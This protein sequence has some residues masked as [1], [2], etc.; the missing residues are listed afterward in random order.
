[1][2]IPALFLPT[3]R[4]IEDQRETFDLSQ[5]VTNRTESSW[6]RPRRRRENYLRAFTIYYIMMMVPRY[7]AHRNI[8]GSA[9]ATNTD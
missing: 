7:V 2:P 4:T 1:M 5:E 3:F 8:H 9:G 6:Y